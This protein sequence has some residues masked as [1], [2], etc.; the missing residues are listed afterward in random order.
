M[1]AN[2]D[3]R[4]K[5]TGAP[6]LILVAA[7]LLG[8]LV[9]YATHRQHNSRAIAG[10]GNQLDRL[11]TELS[12]QTTHSQAMG[13]ITL[14]GLDEPGFK[15][16]AR[17]EAVSAPVRA[18]VRDKLA[19]LR[20]LFDA[21][22]AY[23]VGQRGV[24]LMHATL[25]KNSTGV[26]VNFRPYFKQAMAGQANIYAAVGSNS[27]E[28]GL[29]FAAPIR[30]D[31]TQEG[32]PIGVLVLKLAG[33]PL[34]DRL[35]TVA[36]AALLLSPQG[37]VFATT[38]PDWLFNVAPPIS[39]AR[40]EGIRRLRQFGGRFDHVVPTALPFTPQDGEI[41]LSGRTYLSATR[42]LDW[43]DPAGHWQLVALRDQAAAVSLAY[44][45]R[46]GLAAC[47]LALVLGIAGLALR[48][49]R[50]REQAIQTR[51]RTLSAALEQAPIAVLITDAQRG[52]QWVNPTFER[53]T[54]YPID[55]IRGHSPALLA[56]GLTDQASLDSL[57]Q[58][59]NAGRTWRGELVN[60]HK[61]GH[62]LW[63]HATIS[64][65]FGSG[66]RVVAYVG[67]QEDITEQRRMSERLAEQE[68]RGRLLLD[69]VD[70]G[71]LGLDAHG[72]CTFV[73]PAASR[74]L[75]Y[76]PDA[77]IGQDVHDLI[78]HSFADGSR[79]GR[80]QAPCHRAYAEGVESHRGSEVLW[81]KD[82]TL[83]N[84][85]LSAIPIRHDGT[86]DG[87][88]MVF[89]DI[90]ERLA[91]DKALREAHEELADITATLPVAIFRLH[92]APDGRHEFTYLSGR[93]ESILGVGAD[94]AMANPN[95]L[96][97]CLTVEDREE[98]IRRLIRAGLDMTPYRQELRLED[99]RRW[100]HAEAYSRP[101][102][103]G[104]VLWSG[105]FQDT[106]E[107]K[108]A[109]YAL[110][111]AKQ[112]AEDVARMKSDFLANMSHE[113]RTPMN[114]IVGMTHLALKTD[115]SPKQQEY[116][117]KIQQSGQHL[118]SI[119][120][121][122]LDFSKVEAGKMEIE[123]ADFQL[124]KVLDTVATL[125][126]DKAA[127][128][129][130]ELV[131]DIPADLPDHLVGDPLRLGQI[132]VNY[133]TNAVKFTERGEISVVVRKQSETA[134]DIELRFEVHDTGIGLTEAA[135]SRLFRSFQQ[136]DSSTTRKYGGTGLGLAISK[137]LAE[138]M[139]GRVGVES[140]YGKGST[141][142]FTARLGKSK[143]AP[144]KLLPKPDLRGMRVLVAEDNSHA[145]NVLTEMLDSMSFNVDAVAD[146]AQ[147]VEAV[148]QAAEQGKPYRVLML[149]WR[150]PQMDGRETTHRIQALNLADPPKII[151][152]TAYGREDV[153]RAA[154]AAGVDD[155]LVKPINPS[156][157]F[158]TLMRVMDAEEPFLA[159]LSPDGVGVD[160]SSIAGARILLAEDNELNQEVARELLTQSGFLVDIVGHGEAALEQLARQPYDIV[161]MDMQM[162]VMDGV[163]A[164][165][166]IRS[167]TR[168]ANLPIVAMTAN[169]LASDRELCLKA[170][171]ND[172]IAKP[173]DPNALGK[174]LLKWISPRHKTP[175][176]AQVVEPVVPEHLPEHIPGLD[177]GLGLRHVAN[178]RSLYRSLLSKF[179]TGHRDVPDH[180][181]AALQSGQTETAQRLAHTLKGTAGT[182]GA[183]EIQGLA[184][185][186]ES[187]LR[188][189]QP[190]AVTGSLTE[191]L[192]ER[193]ARLV[194]DIEA[195]LASSGPAPDTPVDQ[196]QLRSV[197][198]T[199]AAHLAEDNM[200]ASHVFEQHAD[201]LKAAMPDQYRALS[202]AIENFDF[203]EALAL[204]NQAR[205]DRAAAQAG[206]TP[207]DR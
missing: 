25:G 43:H 152:V 184:A 91:K 81:R 32:A 22:G 174:T 60:R 122:I 21:N 90:S 15:Q 95:A 52:I 145:R 140:E 11:A 113:I 82:G 170:G 155:I 26:D 160:L 109:E 53:M 104:G 69:T 85:E 177:L 131:F 204:L 132:L 117:R 119:I 57:E 49:S 161:L 166:Q 120:N 5:A 137:S 142:W 127:A 89:R 96:F 97:E 94:T 39:P 163:T 111:E 87:A 29:Y 201:L 20:A 30:P 63:Q 143:T 23:L 86:P 144:R 148:R 183:I 162:P 98:M 102:P 76:A 185:K 149:D 173:I 169:A 141:F 73:N 9:G 124:S 67:L 165:E 192:R 134:R 176:P 71:I 200:L 193:L 153:S 136:A 126:G 108:E 54:G 130:L 191:L 187:S 203:E 175:P 158:D 164:T 157:V 55:E 83:L 1:P 129:N 24:I 19:A 128:K 99:G 205:P 146:G 68:M 188:D 74:L 31:A 135:R 37:V 138:L 62:L 106:T 107:L 150:M 139:G 14:R 65:V 114:A 123:H 197:R 110:R 103:Q 58:A 56:S 196:A 50:R 168:Y 100:I 88:V 41:S 33:A 115:L 125:L 172:H 186:L 79:R 70:D 189:R 6:F 18:A 171:M 8:A 84:V 12:R 178:K 45:L 159:P 133:G 3:V 4:Y 80:N 118:M 112:L 105:Y 75:G 47:L 167:Q 93:V 92:Q 36:D 61:D 27:D 156:M 13:L 154:H 194:N 206:N 34:D 7:L 44:P 181:V 16:I 40:I 46:N 190:E 147:A 182:L 38:Q 116:L 10:L 42:A 198:D 35:R 48:H 77:L 207:V 195:A 17:E 28:R 51:D 2:R 180:I 199:L 151:I 179:V 72:L 202:Q 101:H 121:D 64:P 78:H 59:L 66:H